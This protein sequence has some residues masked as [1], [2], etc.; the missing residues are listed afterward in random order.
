[1]TY[2][3]VVSRESVRIAFLI[4]AVN[5]YDI[6]VVDVQNAYVQ[7]TSLEN[8]LQLLVMSLV[9]TKGKRH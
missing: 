1:L 3:S 5:G 6:I 8:I 9:M 4:A 7:A 2:S